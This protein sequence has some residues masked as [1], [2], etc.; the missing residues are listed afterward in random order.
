MVNE[1]GGTYHRAFKSQIIDIVITEK[2]KTNT[3]KFQAAVN[4]RKDILLPEWIFDSVE[5]GYALPT[6]NYEVKSLKISTPTKTGQKPAEF[7]C[8]DSTQVS[9]ISHISTIGVAGGGFHK[10]PKRVISTTLDYTICSNM[11]DSAASF[12][13]F[14]VPANTT[15]KGGHLNKTTAKT[16]KSKTAYQQVLASICPQKAK[17]A[18]N[19]LD[20]CE[21]Y[22][23]GFRNEEREKL[24]RILNTGGATRYDAFNEKVTHVIVGEFNPIESKSW[25]M[26]G[27]SCHIVHLEWL[28]ESIQLRQPANELKHNISLSEFLP[29]NAPSPSSKKILRS[30]NHSFMQPESSTVKKQL[31]AIGQKNN[32]SID[33]GVELRQSMSTT[34]TDGA[35]LHLDN[36]EEEIL[37][38]EYSQKNIQKMPTGKDCAELSLAPLACSTQISRP[39]PVI[40]NQTDTLIPTQTQ[41]RLM[42]FFQGMS[43]YVDKEHFTD[44]F[45]SDILSECD[46]AGGCIVNKNFRDVVD[47]AIV[48]LEHTFDTKTLPVK[49]KNV[50]TE[51]YVVCEEQQH[52]MIIN[53]TATFHLLIT[54]ELFGGEQAGTY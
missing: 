3:D 5:K 51:L 27:N 48:S 35:T 50:V 31:F 17:R 34:T 49:A 36:E 45:Y 20:G 47:Y 12:A 8:A 33:N 44:D 16:V 46:A 24:N 39:G 1:N 53:I 41:N 7:I 32:E 19:F 37:M 42:N 30:M 23:S 15:E 21:V 22:L 52:Y 18:G 6:M 40:E 25:K 13:S 11:N 4:Y 28:Q 29:P 43:I 54:G 9:D 2:D 38:A 26:N 14:S 10:D